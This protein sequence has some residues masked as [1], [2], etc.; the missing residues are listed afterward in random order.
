MPISFNEEVVFENEFFKGVVLFMLKT[1]PEHP[2][3]VDHFKGKQRL[4]EMQI[5]GQFKKLPDGERTER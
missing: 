5:Q 2:R 3:F 1:N 4:F